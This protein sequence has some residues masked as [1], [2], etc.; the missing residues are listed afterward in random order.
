MKKQGA[1][2]T[3]A[4]L[5]PSLRRIGTSGKLSRYRLVTPASNPGCANQLVVVLARWVVTSVQLNYAT[6]PFTEKENP[7]AIR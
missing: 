4:L 1:G 5:K 3:P 2:G 6:N 7:N